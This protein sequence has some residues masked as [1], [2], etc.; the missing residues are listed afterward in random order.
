MCHWLSDL[1]RRI[2]FNKPSQESS[3]LC[4]EICFF[5]TQSA[6]RVQIPSKY[7]LSVRRKRAGGRATV[8]QN[9]LIKPAHVSQW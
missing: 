7:H 4:N 5:I 8:P 6:I 3:R 1:S 9:V 2:S